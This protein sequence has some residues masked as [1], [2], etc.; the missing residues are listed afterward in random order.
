MYTSSKI[1]KDVTLDEATAILTHNLPG[2]VIAEYT[3]VSGG[4]FNTTYKIVTT[5]PRRELIMRVGPIHRELLLPYERHLMDAEALTNREMTA[6]GIPTPKL[7]VCDTTKTIIDR[8][9]MITEYMDSVALS[10][11]SVPEECRDALYEESGRIMRAMH[12]I[13][14]ERFGRV[15]D[16]FDGKS[17]NTWSEFLISHIT[18]LGSICVEFEVFEHEFIDRVVAM[19]THCRPLFEAITQPFLTHADIWAG[20][21]LVKQVDGEL[22]VTAIID[23]DR[24]V[25]GDIDFELGSPWIMGEPFFRGY[26]EVTDSSDRR[27]RLKLYCLMYN[28]ID[29][30]VWRV[31]YV[32]DHE[33]EVNRDRAYETLK[34]LE[35]NI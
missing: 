21:I 29:T 14:G 6:H 12:A 34:W 35:E 28:L 23:A 18:E 17:Y 1:Y 32:N 27:K 9:Y 15:G 3:P 13:K 4:L 25:Y 22:H 19:Y 7:V 24:A 8:D 33:Y 11:S 20:N 10:D 31:E 30:Y 26:G 2:A 5:E 16:F